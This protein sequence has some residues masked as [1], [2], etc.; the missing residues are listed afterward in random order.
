VGRVCVGGIKERNGYDSRSAGKEQS[1]FL[2]KH[3]LSK[4]SGDCA[5]LIIR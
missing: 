1:C 2:E 3:R 4:E 5:R